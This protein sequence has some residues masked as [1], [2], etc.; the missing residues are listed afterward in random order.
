MDAR[1]KKALRYG[2][3]SLG[4]VVGIPLK[5]VG[6]IVLV[7]VM[8]GIMLTM[9]GALY[10]RKNLTSNLAVDLYSYTLNQTSTIWCK[11]KDGEWFK[12]ETLQSK[13][14]RELA[15]FGEIPENMINALIAVEDKRFYSHKGVDWYRT[16]GAFTNMF[17]SSR[18]SFGGSS[19][20]QQLIKNLT[21]EKDVTVKRK[22]TEIFRALEFEKH[23]TKEE[24]LTWYF[25][26]CYFGSSA[27]GVKVAA[28]TYFDKDL[29][30]L[31]V[32]ESASI[33]GITNSPT[34]YNPFQNPENNKD[35][36]EDIL[37]KMFEQGMLTEA[38]YTAAVE[39][40]LQFKHGNKPSERG[41][42]SYF[43][44][45]VFRDVSADLAK[46][47][48]WTYA[49][50]QQTVLN[51]GY[52]IYITMDMEIQAIIDDI[53]TNEENIPAVR[54]LEKPQAA[55]VLMDP[56]TGEV[57]GMS[58]GIG[59]KEGSL[60][61]NRAVQSVR[62]PGSSIKPIGVYAPAMEADLITPYSVLDD[63]PIRSEKGRA[64]P[65]NSGGGYKGLTTVQSGVT[66]STNTIAAQTISLLTP[67]R[68]HSFLI[69]SLGITSLKD[70][71]VTYSLSL[72]GLTRGISVLEMTAAFCTF[73]NRG[74]YI[75][76]RTYTL[77]MS[78]TE[79]VLDNRPQ[80][81]AA[82]KEKNAWYMNNMLQA[83]VQSGTGARAKLKV[84]IPAAGKT[85][86]TTE[87]KDR[88][89]VGYTPYYCGGVWF[90]FDDPKKISLE[91]STNPA[92]ALWKMV[93][94]RVHEDLER[95][96]FFNID[97][98]IVRASYCLDS[99]LKP[100]ENCSLDP[101]GGRVATGAFH[102]DDLP[103]ESCSVH[104]L[105]DQ[106][107]ESGKLATPYCPSENIR[108]IALLDFKREL[109]VSV[110]IDD[111]AY[112]IRAA[113]E[114]YGS[115][116]EEDKAN[117]YCPLHTHADWQ[118]ELPPLEPELDEPDEGETP[119][120]DDDGNETDLPE[121]PPLVFTWQTTHSHPRTATVLQTAFAAARRPRSVIYR[122]LARH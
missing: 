107:S 27:Y 95:R 2:R 48:G 80:V 89:F 60:S 29:S 54:G 40:P 26:T 75:K 61:L 34:K 71:D 25:N 58:G 22:M 36:Q 92:L 77:V 82:I 88:W 28:R 118:A 96:E 122:P 10:I 68:A 99:G 65:R 83:V 45:Q 119:P 46:K 59:E 62:Q 7:F 101:R 69:E 17:T 117:D 115:V 49:L 3:R 87:D 113:D 50:A 32:A 13:E 97:S 86:T 112:L 63:A 111:G 116:S 79:P 105:V 6:T 35:R 42:Q 4:R 85:G 76:P 120:P 9:I 30:E 8:T 90:G 78:G 41:A 18:S 16:V 94:D 93:M 109:P 66:R 64:W 106:D 14:N 38:E 31:T 73:P 44:D 23:Y 84:N 108:K 52:D 33:I 103:K 121:I 72:G 39:Q 5:I 1:T 114:D 110:S 20:T 53:F 37:E 57:L 67:E 11:D 55:M 21:E 104:V 43:I 12:L 74:E 70:T 24:I 98:E 100:T 91:Q 47:T 102:K 19:I 51:G 15:Q 56:Y 81:T